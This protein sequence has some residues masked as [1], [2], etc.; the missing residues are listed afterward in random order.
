M[1][2]V[3]ALFPGVMLQ[4]FYKILPLKQPSVTSAP[5]Q[6][7]KLNELTVFSIFIFIKPN[8]QKSH[9]PV[10]LTP[11]YCSPTFTNYHFMHSLSF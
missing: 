5:K 2:H 11:V 10:K 9:R 4:E 1:F 7:E 3:I 6:M 8:L